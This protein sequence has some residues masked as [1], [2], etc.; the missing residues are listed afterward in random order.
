MQLANLMMLAVAAAVVMTASVQG[1]DLVDV[2]AC[3]AA[4][5]ADPKKIV[6]SVRTLLGPRITP[7]Y[8]LITG[9]HFRCHA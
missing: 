1:N 8:L 7:P 5:A 2:T 3:R 9:A 4:V 6:G